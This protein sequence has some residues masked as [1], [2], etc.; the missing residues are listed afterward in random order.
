MHSVIDLLVIMAVAIVP[1]KDIFERKRWCRQYGLLAAQM[2][3]RLAIADV[4][5]K[6]WIVQ[7]MGPPCIWTY[8]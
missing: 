3:Y 7:M 8:C 6:P 5:S 1:D 4:E 2:V